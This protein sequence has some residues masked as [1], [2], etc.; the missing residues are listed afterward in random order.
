M[1]ILG[2]RQISSSKRR[3]TDWGTEVVEGVDV[4]REEGRG[5]PG[6]A[7]EGDDAEGVAEGAESA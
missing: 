3:G 1:D 4:E 5:T 6:E 7:P 2:M